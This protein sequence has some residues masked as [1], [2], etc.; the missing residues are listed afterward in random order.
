MKNK[1]VPP[2]SSTLY[3]M[4]YSIKIACIKNLKFTELPSTMLKFFKGL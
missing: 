1:D 3:S 2:N 4:I